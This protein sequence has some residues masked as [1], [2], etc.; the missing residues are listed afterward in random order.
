MCPDISIVPF[1]SSLLDKPDI[2]ICLYGSCCHCRGVGTASSWSLSRLDALA[3][4]VK[5]CF[6]AQQMPQSV[7][8]NASSHSTGSASED[9]ALRDRQASN[10]KAGSSTESQ[11]DVF[12][13]R[14]WQ[15][16]LAW[17]VGKVREVKQKPPHLKQQVPEGEAPTL[18][19][20]LLAMQQYPMQTVAAINTVLFDRH[21]YNRMQLHGNPR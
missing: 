18:D 9:A 2:H 10:S 19:P 20:V 17:A 4:E 14:V 15:P 13:K 16:L 21:G 7:N 8:T 6:L 12:I 11:Q 1:A 5:T 3:D